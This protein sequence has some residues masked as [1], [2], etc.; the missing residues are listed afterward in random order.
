MGLSDTSMQIPIVHKPS[1]VTLSGWLPNYKLVA[2]DTVI[3]NL[4]KSAFGPFRRGLP[5]ETL[6]GRV[7]SSL[8]G[9]V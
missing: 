6:A 7:L 3:C 5:E 4:E 8:C 2:I 1:G 9:G